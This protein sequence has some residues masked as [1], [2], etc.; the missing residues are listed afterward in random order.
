[1]VHE[2]PRGATVEWYTPKSL[3]DALGLAFYMDVASPRVPVPWVPAKYH[4]WYEGAVSDW[5]GMVWC[6]PPYGPAAVPFVHR[7]A[8]HRAGLLLL[9]SRTETRA[10]QLA[11][12]KADRVCFLRERLHFTRADGFTAR[13]SFGSTLFAWSPVACRAIRKA[14]LGKWFDNRE[15]ID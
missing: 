11:L 9:P 12:E 1:M 4:L 13:S 8:E 15:E 2:K 14:S 5:R 3:F 10:F 6:N 7:M